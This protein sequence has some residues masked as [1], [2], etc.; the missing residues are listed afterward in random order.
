MEFIAFLACC[1]ASWN[2]ASKSIPA[3]ERPSTP[4]RQRLFSSPCPSSP[5]ALLNPGRTPAAAAVLSRASA[6]RMTRFWHHSRKTIRCRS[7]SDVGKPLSM[8]LSAAIP[9]IRY[10]LGRGCGSSHLLREHLRSAT[11]SAAQSNA[12]ISSFFCNFEDQI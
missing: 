7:W 3:D 1:E 12:R 11:A 4:P 10:R 8:L 9:I 2:N 6:A 5:A